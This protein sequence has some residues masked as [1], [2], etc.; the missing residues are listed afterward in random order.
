M[1]KVQLI[2]ICPKYLA[3]APVLKFTP[4]SNGP[5]THQTKRKLQL[6]IA[7]PAWADRAQMGDLYKEA[8]AITRESGILHV[9]DHIVPLHHRLVCG[10]HVPANL[11]IVSERTNAEKHNRFNSSDYELESGRTVHEQQVGLDRKKK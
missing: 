9:V 7:T 5:F 6:R 2:P 1:V 3:E 10:L 11:R 8:R 4:S